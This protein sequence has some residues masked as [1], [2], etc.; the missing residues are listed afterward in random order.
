[1][2]MRNRRLF[3]ATAVAAAVAA[4]AIG[5]FS[6]RVQNSN[7]LTRASAAC[8]VD[9]VDKGARPARFLSP[10]PSTPEDGPV[11]KGF[12]LEPGRAR[13]AMGRYI[14]TKSENGYERVVGE[15]GVFATRQSNGASFGVPNA[16]APAARKPALSTNS[17]VHN[18]RTLQH[19]LNAGLPKD[20][21]ASAHVS[22]LMQSRGEAGDPQ[23]DPGEFV[24][25]TSNIDRAVDGVPVGDSSAWARFNADDE[26]VEEGAFWPDVP[27]SVVDT[28]KNMRA[29]LDDPDLRAEYLAKLPPAA[30]D[31]G[32]VIIRHS[33]WTIDAAPTFFASYDFSESNGA[34][35][36]VMRHFDI[37]GNEFR[38]PQETADQGLATAEQTKSR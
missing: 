34:G 22:T 19:F 2:N 38:L 8:T 4:V 6:R 25:F 24:A 12:R 10:P 15:H 37:A 14:E 16:D 7:A 9:P 3:A 13:F 20:Q 21:V 30:R 5:S 18:D 35:L 11:I 28:A 1:M 31:N 33:A 23:N 17:D 27:P 32:R 26:V 36:S 29:M